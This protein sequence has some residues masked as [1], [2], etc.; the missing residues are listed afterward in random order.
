MRSSKCSSQPKVQKTLARKHLKNGCLVL[1]D[2]T[3]SY[4]EGEYKGSDLAVSQP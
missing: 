2:I 1:Y 4:F 3:S